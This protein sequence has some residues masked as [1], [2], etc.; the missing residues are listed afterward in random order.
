MNL[1]GAVDSKNSNLAVFAK[2]WGRV[3]LPLNFIVNFSSSVQQPYIVEYIFRT[4]CFEKSLPCRD[5]IEFGRAPG[6]SPSDLRFW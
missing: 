1:G 3:C 5:D 2:F 4:L 6:C